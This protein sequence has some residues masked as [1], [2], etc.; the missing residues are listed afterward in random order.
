VRLDLSIIRDF[1]LGRLVVKPQ[2]DLFNIFNVSPVT[3]EVA[4][5]GTS[6]G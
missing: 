3:N 1:R 4:T 6:L 2:L 5:F